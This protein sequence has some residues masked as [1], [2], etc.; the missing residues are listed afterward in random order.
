MAAAPHRDGS[1][2]P[3]RIEGAGGAGLKQTAPVSVSSAAERCETV[4]DSSKGTGV[5][6]VDDKMSEETQVAGT[7]QNEGSCQ[8]SDPSLN[9]GPK[10]VG[11]GSSIIV[12]PRQVCIVFFHPLHLISVQAQVIGTPC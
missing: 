9:L 1:S 4:Q 2:K 3:L 5:R 8:K 7:E 10:P 11:S 6:A 12:S